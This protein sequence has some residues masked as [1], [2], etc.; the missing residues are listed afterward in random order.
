[1][2]KIISVIAVIAMIAVMS[3]S[4]F[5]ANDSTANANEILKFLKD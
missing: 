5:A 4:A 2:K 3:V 1:M